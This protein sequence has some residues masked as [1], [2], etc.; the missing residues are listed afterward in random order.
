MQQRAR[1]RPHANAH[2]TLCHEHPHASNDARPHAHVLAQFTHNHA[3]ALAHA[4][5][6]AGPANAHVPMRG[7]CLGS[8]RC[9]CHALQAHLR[10][11]RPSL[12]RF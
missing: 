8:R 4:H 5:A 11:R 12:T 2:Q 9:R 3:R 10:A 7:A 6:R 1:A